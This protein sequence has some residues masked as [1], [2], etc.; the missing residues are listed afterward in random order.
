MKVIHIG[1]C[2]CIWCI[3]MYTYG[4]MYGRTGIYRAS[5]VFVTPDHGNQIDV[6][7]E[8]SMETGLM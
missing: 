5:G 4:V 1:I 2:I 7:M 6:K 3:Y 8:N